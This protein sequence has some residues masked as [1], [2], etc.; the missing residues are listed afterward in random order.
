MSVLFTARH[1]QSQGQV[2]RAN[3]TL[4]R[5]LAKTLE[6]NKNWISV[7]T[8]VVQNCKTE[9]EDHKEISTPYID[10]MVADANANIKKFNIG[11]SILTE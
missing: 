3:Q 8:S 6:E 11:D 1:P 9:V 4:K 5:W 7:I 10:G 2:E